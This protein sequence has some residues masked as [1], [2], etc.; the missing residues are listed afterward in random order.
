LSL[1]RVILTRDIKFN[2]TRRYLDK[3][4]PIETPE[5]KEVVRVIKIP[6]LDLYSKKDS[7][8]EEYELSINMLADIIIIQDEIALPTTTYNMTSR[9]CPIRPIDV[10][11]I[12]LLS[13]EITP[14]P[15]QET[16][17]DIPA[18]DLIILIYESISSDKRA[19]EHPIILMAG[20]TTE[21][22]AKK[23]TLKLLKELETDL[24]PESTN[25]SSN[26]R[27]KHPRYQAY[28]AMLDNL[29]EN[30]TSLGLY[31]AAF[32][33]A[34]QRQPR[35]HRSNVLTAPDRWK[36]ILKH[37]Y[38]KGFIEA[39][40]IEHSTLISQTIWTEITQEQLNGAI[41]LLVR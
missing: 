1:Y 34:I 19:E 9:Y 16:T 4:K 6:S 32:G 3:D 30:P 8:L 24:N 13:P 28:T 12:Q 23:K 11:I 15:E 14:E 31:L 18:F 17:N 36:Q 20:G 21:P 40:R 26:K 41:P 22:P 39:A 38:T 7:V 33:T 25:P 10:P 5:A 35:L 2:K 27:Q 29:M 37:K